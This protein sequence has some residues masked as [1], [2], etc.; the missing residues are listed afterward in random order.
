MPGRPPRYSPELKE[1]AIKEVIGGKKSVTQ[2]GSTDEN[3]EF[4]GI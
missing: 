1:Q 3:P 4:A 2:P